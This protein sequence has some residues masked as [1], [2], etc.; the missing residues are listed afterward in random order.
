MVEDPY[1]D[2]A[3]I[4]AGFECENCFAYFHE[5]TN[6]EAMGKMAKDLGWYVVPKDDDWTVLCP[7]CKPKE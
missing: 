2:V 4:Y 6:D 1:A 5:H 7:A 3:L